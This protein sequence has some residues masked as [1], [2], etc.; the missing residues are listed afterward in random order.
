[1]CIPIALR[2]LA[3]VCSSIAASATAAVLQPITNWDVDYGETQCTA[4]RSFGSASAPT[5]FAIVPSLGGDTYK[6]IVSVPRPGPRFAEEMQGTVDFGHAQ[7]KSWLLY[8][9]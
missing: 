6:L 7:I 4:G 1:M 8:Y 2:L 3:V 9:G 5:L